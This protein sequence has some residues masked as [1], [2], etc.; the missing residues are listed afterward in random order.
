MCQWTLQSTI[1][2]ITTQESRLGARQS[3]LGNAPVHLTMNG[4][5]HIGDCVA[6]AR[7]P[8]LRCWD[9]VIHRCLVC[10]TI[11]CEICAHNAV[12][13][14]PNNGT[15][16]WIG[17]QGLEA[18]QRQVGMQILHPSMVACSSSL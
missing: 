2:S 16:V 18:E 14:T 6:A 1:N 5:I 9:L 11:K 3:L 12:A 7:R 8:W 13:D 4:I 15:E 10:D 17:I